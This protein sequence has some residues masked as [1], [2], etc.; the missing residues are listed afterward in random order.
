LEF[1]HSA[2]TATRFFEE[3]QTAVDYLRQIIISVTPDC[4]TTPKP[5]KIV[6]FAYDF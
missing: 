6:S 1:Q 5:G 3:L 4:P 2:F